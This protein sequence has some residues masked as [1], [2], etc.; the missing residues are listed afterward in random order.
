MKTNVAAEVCRAVKDIDRQLFRRKRRTISYRGGKALHPKFFGNPVLCLSD[1]IGVED[2][3][4]AAAKISG[5]QFANLVGGQSNG[6]TRRVHARQRARFR[7]NKKR[8]IVAA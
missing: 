3:H 1:S 8:R 7:S 6:W 5:R 4:I 2:Q